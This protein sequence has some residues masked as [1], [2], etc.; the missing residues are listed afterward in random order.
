MVEQKADNTCT[1]ITFPSPLLSCLAEDEAGCNGNTCIISGNRL[2]ELSSSSLVAPS[3]DDT[4]DTVSPSSGFFLSTPTTTSSSPN[5]D[6]SPLSIAGTTPLA[7]DASPWPSA[8]SDNSDS[9]RFQP[10]SQDSLMPTSSSSS[11]RPQSDD[12]LI[13]QQRQLQQEMDTLLQ[14]PLFVAPSPVSPF[15]GSSDD[16]TWLLSSRLS[17]PARFQE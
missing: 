7:A 6:S 12:L 5:T 10:L 11:V 13:S 16:L 1:T 3:P 9:D 8:P 4:T 14:E 15:L 17:P 2:E